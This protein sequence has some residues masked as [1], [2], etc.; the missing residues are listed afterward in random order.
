MDKSIVAGEVEL[1]LAELMR[2][3]GQNVKGQILVVGCSTSEVAGE[4]IGT[5]GSLEIARNIFTALQ[6]VTE[7]CG[8]HLAIQCC[9]HLNRALVVEKSTADTFGLERVAVKPVLNA[10]GALA[11]T[12]Y[13]SFQE[14]VVIEQLRADLGLDIGQTF[15]GMHLKRVV[16]PVRLTQKTIGAAVLSAA[17]TRPPYIGGPRAVYEI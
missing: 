17:R 1:A 12:A 9:E 3:T 13:E 14:P 10:G 16:V 15:I 11:A 5:A 2:S 7:Q 8:V 4:R 6:K